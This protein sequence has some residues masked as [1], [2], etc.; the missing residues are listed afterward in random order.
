MKCM[1]HFIHNASL[2]VLHAIADIFIVG[3]LGSIVVLVLT[4]FE[5]LRTVFHSE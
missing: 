1:E 2:W 4:F 5:D 3:M